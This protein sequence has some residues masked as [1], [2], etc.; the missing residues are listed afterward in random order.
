MTPP[1]LLFWQRRG[2][3]METVMND[4]DVLC[5]L[6]ARESEEQEEREAE[7]GPEHFAIGEDCQWGVFFEGRDLGWIPCDTYIEAQWCLQDADYKHLPGRIG[8]R[9]IGEIEFD[10]D[11]FRV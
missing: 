11:D 8:R 2:T 4:H 7:I 5:T 6:C 1:L 9:P 3:S 10:E